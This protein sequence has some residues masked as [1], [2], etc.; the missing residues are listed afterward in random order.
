MVIRPVLVRTVNEISRIICESYSQPKIPSAEAFTQ[1]WHASQAL[2]SQ[3]F[4]SQSPAL[5]KET[6]GARSSDPAPSVERDL[7]VNPFR[8]ELANCSLGESRDGAT[9]L[10]LTYRAP[11][12]QAPALRD[13]KRP[14]QK[15]AAQPGS[16][17]GH[18][19]YFVKVAEINHR[20]SDHSIE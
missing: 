15:R 11:P 4:F 2:A 16:G 18:R 9:A 1:Q 10:R 7:N 17:L 20:V 8:V 13:G 3:Y 5:Q 6:R 12:A 19:R 14:E